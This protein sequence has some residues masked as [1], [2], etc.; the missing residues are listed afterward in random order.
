[1]DPSTVGYIG[2]DG[3]RTFFE[4]NRLSGVNLF[5]EGKRDTRVGVDRPSIVNHILVRAGQSEEVTKQSV[6]VQAG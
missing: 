2:R 3:G 4:R 6:I 5:M 1:M